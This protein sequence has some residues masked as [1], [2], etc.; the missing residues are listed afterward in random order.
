MVGNKEECDKV[1]VSGA[2]G[3]KDICEHDYIITQLLEGSCL[4]KAKEGGE[5]IFFCSTPKTEG[6]RLEEV[7]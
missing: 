5:G 3:E 7:V 4:W 6:S 2:Y 1:F